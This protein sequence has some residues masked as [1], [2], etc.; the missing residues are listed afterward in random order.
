MQN[1]LAQH[2]RPAPAFLEICRRAP[3]E[4]LITAYACGLRDS[5][6]ASEVDVLRAELLRRLDLITAATPATE[7]HAQ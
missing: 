1:R 4:K 3:V 6:P 7:R 5:A 2:M